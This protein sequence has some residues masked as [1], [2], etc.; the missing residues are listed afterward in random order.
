VRP[1]GVRVNVSTNTVYNLGRE[2]INGAENTSNLLRSTWDHRVDNRNKEVVDAQVGARYT[3]NDVRYSL[4][5]R[6]DRSYVSR[7]FYSQL[8]VRLPEGWRVM[9]GLDYQLYSGDVFGPGR[10]VPLLRAEVSRM[11]LNDR[12]ELRLEGRDLLDR[13]VG[14]DYSNT[15]TYVQ[16]ER[17]NTLGRY[18]MLRAVYNLAGAR[19]PGGMVMQAAGG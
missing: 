15:A 3:F 16:E 7:A 10:H 19:R 8:R 5:S 4:N 14:V 12:V 11:L 2:I 6:L 18:V 17:V 1:L 9:A 13:N